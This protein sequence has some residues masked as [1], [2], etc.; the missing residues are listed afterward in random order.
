LD[1]DIDAIALAMA[2]LSTRAP[3]GFP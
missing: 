1:F 3:E 2:N